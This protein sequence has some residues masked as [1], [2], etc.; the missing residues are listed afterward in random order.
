MPVGVNSALRT[1]LFENVSTAGNVP[2]GQLAALRARSHDFGFAAK[3]DIQLFVRTCGF[4]FL[5]TT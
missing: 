3:A 4:L 5:G 2:L 1:F